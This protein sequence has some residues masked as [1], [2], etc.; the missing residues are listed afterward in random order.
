MALG[1]PPALEVEIAFE[2]ETR[3]KG[4]D[5]SGIKEENRG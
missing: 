2:T 3:T 1:P 4:E 5:L